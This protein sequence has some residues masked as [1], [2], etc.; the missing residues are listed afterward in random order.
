MHRR[1]LGQ[2][3]VNATGRVRAHRTRAQPD[4]PIDYLLRQAALNQSRLPVHDAAPFRKKWLEWRADAVN[5]ARNRFCDPSGSPA[6]ET[7]SADGG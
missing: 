1:G 4:R 3:L 2:T 5:T 6:S 7:E